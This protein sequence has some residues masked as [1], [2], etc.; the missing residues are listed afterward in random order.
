[1]LG[2]SG[3]SIVKQRISHHSKKEEEQSSNQEG[4][5][6]DYTPKSTHPAWRTEGRTEDSTYHL[7][8]CLGPGVPSPV[9]SLTRPQLGLPCY[10]EREMRM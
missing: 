9:P 1:M 6:Q 2:T 3:E 8:T 10:I 4:L 7:Y 5:G